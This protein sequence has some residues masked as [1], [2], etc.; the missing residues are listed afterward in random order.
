MRAQTEISMRRIA[1]VLEEPTSTVGRW[2]GPPRQPDGV[3]RPRPV[4]QDAT[5]RDRVVALC[6]EDRHKTYGHRRIRALLWR[7][8]GQRV[9]RKTAARVMKD[10]GLDQERVRY[11]PA[12]PKRVERMRPEAPNRAWQVD[13]TSFQLADL[14]PLYLEVVVDCYS[15]KIVGW[16]LDRRCRAREWISAVRMALES[17]QLSPEACSTLVL[18]SDNG[19]QPCSKAFVDYLAHMGVQGQYTG[20]NAPDDN[21]Y[22]ERMMRTIKEEEI[23]QNQYESWS[24]AHQAIDRYVQYYNRERIHSALDYRTPIEAE[25][26]GASLKAA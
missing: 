21:A 12:R 26:N 20:Y 6:H 2:C 9:A 4:R 19:A 22:I 24:E 17:Q 13:M 3:A 5:L 25:A 7:R 15:R 11:K 10:L 14:T 16:A 1:R 8:Y 23:W 18:R